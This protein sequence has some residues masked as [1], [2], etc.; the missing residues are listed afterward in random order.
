ME[1]RRFC[2][3]SAEMENLEHFIRE[4]REAFNEGALHDG[5]LQR[6]EARLRAANLR[7]PAEG[8]WNFFRA[9]MRRSVA[10]AA[11][12]VLLLAT[13]VVLYTGRDDYK[14]KVEVLTSQQTKLMEEVSREINQLYGEEDAEREMLIR[15]LE[16]IIQE[17]QPLEKQLPKELDEKERLRILKEYYNE[18]ARAIL[19]FKKLLTQEESG[20]LE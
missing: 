8:R 3:E 15:S 2:K 1:E 13:G 10:A 9:G 16:S 6:F 17:A 4:N 14:A 20:V 7:K 5:H 12:I 19:R 11:I 18:R